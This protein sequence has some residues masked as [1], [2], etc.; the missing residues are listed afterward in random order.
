MRGG[1]RIDGKKPCVTSLSCLEPIR[2]VTAKTPSVYDVLAFRSASDLLNRVPLA[3]KEWTHL[4]QA[5]ALDG[6]GD[7]RAALLAEAG[8]LHA[9]GDGGQLAF[10]FVAQTVTTEDAAQRL[11]WEIKLLGLPVSVHPLA[12][13]EARKRPARSLSELPQVEGKSV[14]VAGTRL[15]G[16]TGGK[17]WF[18][19]DEESYVVAIP[20]K[21][22]ANPRPW[23]PVQLSGRW[24]C[25]QWG[26]CWFQIDRWEA[27]E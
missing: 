5:G 18:C 12:T 17:G 20:A 26:D 10:T 11:A 21:G 13:V 27:L 23:R 1:R 25:D 22:L 14:T 3:R 9:G 2:H 15:P 7:S 16:W 19:A 6:L 8:A 4:I 24:T